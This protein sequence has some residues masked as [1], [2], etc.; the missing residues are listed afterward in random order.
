MVGKKED[1][2]V[3][4][5]NGKAHASRKRLKR[6]DLLRFAFI[7]LVGVLVNLLGQ[8]FIHA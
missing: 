2:K 1:N 8:R 4:P 7:V 6:Y 5:G 3:P